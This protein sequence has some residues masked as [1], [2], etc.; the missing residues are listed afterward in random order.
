[1][2]LPDRRAVIRPAPDGLDRP[3][4]ELAEL[5]VLRGLNPWCGGPAVL[6]ELRVADAP[7]PDQQVLLDA[8]V[9]ALPGLREPLGLDGLDGR[10]GHAGLLPRLPLG[11][12]APLLV[13]HVAGELQRQAGA[14]PPDGRVVPGD[15]GAW[16]VLVGY[17]DEEIGVQSARAAVALV[18]GLLAGGRRVAD[19]VTPQGVDEVIAG[20]RAAVEARRLGPSTRAIVDAAR[21]RG[22]PVRRLD[23]GVLVQLGTGRWQRRVRAALT[24]GDGCLAAEIAQDKA[25]TKRLLAAV[26]LPTPEGTVVDDLPGALDAAARLGFPVLLKPHDG[27]Q[28]RGVSGRLD[29][30]A[31]LRAAW[32][33]AAAVSPRVIVERFVPGRDYRVLVVGGR[34]VACAERL[35]A[36]VVGDG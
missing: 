3:A 27:N 1:M 22:I 32:P 26:G 5:R 20:L 13:Q 9:R 16:T 31:M 36:H 15:G 21:R 8:L 4:L 18:R 12:L 28:G 23:D 34:V 14:A 11:V 30:A 6:C 29:D 17:D 33:C 24:S 25:L 7:A 2:T 19:G 10:P 35:P